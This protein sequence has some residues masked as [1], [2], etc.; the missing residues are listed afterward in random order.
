[1]EERGLVIG[2]RGGAGEI[3]L[4]VFNASQFWV[5]EGVTV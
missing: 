2:K 3:K 5:C 1:M 4:A